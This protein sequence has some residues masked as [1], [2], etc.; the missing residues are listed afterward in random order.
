MFVCFFENISQLKALGRDESSTKGK[1]R[2]H[3]LLRRGMYLYG[4]VAGAR[5]G[6]LYTFGVA[7]ATPTSKSATPMHASATPT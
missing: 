1:L 4:K 3:T 5:G 7:R 6:D 2:T